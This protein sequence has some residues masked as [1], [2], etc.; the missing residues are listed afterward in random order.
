MKPFL[1]L[2]EPKEW[3]FIGLAVPKVDEP[4]TVFSILRKSNYATDQSV[5][6]VIFK[7]SSGIAFTDLFDRSLLGYGRT[8]G[9]TFFQIA[10]LTIFF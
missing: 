2:K 7:T 10:F 3:N 1:F 4:Q 9:K 8:D 5:R 6:F